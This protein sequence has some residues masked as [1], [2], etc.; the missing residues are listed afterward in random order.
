MVEDGQIFGFGVDPE[1]IPKEDAYGR[2]IHN[3]EANY[4]VDRPTKEFVWEWQSSDPKLSID[5]LD[6][7]ETTRKFIDRWL[8]QQLGP[9]GDR[10]DPTDITNRIGK[11]VKIRG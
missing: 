8:D 4:N 2:L 6:N 10:I 11:T 9:K 1:L 3:G 5:D 7:I